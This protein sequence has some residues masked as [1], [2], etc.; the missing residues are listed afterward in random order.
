MKN[1]Q[2]SQVSGAAA[3]EEQLDAVRPTRG[4]SSLIPRRIL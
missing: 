4:A 1:P 3:R 2:S